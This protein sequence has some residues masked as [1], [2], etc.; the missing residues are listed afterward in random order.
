MASNI[1]SAE[2]QF[3]QLKLNISQLPNKFYLLMRGKAGKLGLSALRKLTREPGSPRYPLR[4]QSARQRRAFF[5]TRGFGRGIPYRRTGKLLA[6]W[7]V[8][9]EK[10]K[11][12][13]N[14]VL[15]N[16]SEVARYVQ[17]DRVQNFHLDT[18]WVQVEDVANDFYRDVETSGIKVWAQVCGETAEL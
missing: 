3:R 17:Y 6:G 1:S 9:I 14:V 8:V 15:R 4:W 7:G 11:E 10:T 16:E 2:R 5:A 12:G 18:G 13:A